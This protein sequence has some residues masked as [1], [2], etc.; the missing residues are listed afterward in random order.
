M[1]PMT[2]QNSGRN[3]LVG[4]WLLEKLGVP[5]DSSDMALKAMLL[6]QNSLCDCRD[7]SSLGIEYGC[8]NPKHERGL[9]KTHYGNQKHVHRTYKDPVNEKN[10]SEFLFRFLQNAIHFS[11]EKDYP[12]IKAMQVSASESAKKG[13][14]FRYSDI[15][16]M[17]GLERFPY[18]ENAKTHKLVVAVNYAFLNHIIQHKPLHLKNPDI[19]CTVV[20]QDPSPT[21]PKDIPVIPGLE[22]F[23]IR[24]ESMQN[25]RL[26]GLPR[27]VSAIFPVFLKV[28]YPILVAKRQPVPIAS[29]CTEIEDHW[30]KCKMFLE[31]FLTT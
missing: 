14:P 13:Q 23:V 9:C 30:Q 20:R 6:G 21:C 11:S 27:N 22:C 31:N 15:V 28:Y 4:H 17:L 5:L 18:Q 3:S 24:H 12:H 26:E 1:Q 7:F 2:F 10:I 8:R 29:D 19:K 16:N 25:L